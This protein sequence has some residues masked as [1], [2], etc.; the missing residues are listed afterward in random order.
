MM[1]MMMA[2]STG[3]LPL[4]RAAQ[5]VSFLLHLFYLINALRET[6]ALTLNKSNDDPPI[7]HIDV[8]EGETLSMNCS[9]SKAD[10]RDKVVWQR[11]G[12]SD[13]ILTKNKKVK[14]KDSRV[15]MEMYEDASNFTYRLTILNTSTLDDGKY[16]CVATWKNSTSV[17]FG[18]VTVSVKFFP[19]DNPV[20]SIEND[21]PTCDTAQGNPPVTMNWTTHGTG[22]VLEGSTPNHYVDG[23]GRGHLRSEICTQKVNL[24]NRVLVC[25]VSG[26][27]V[28]SG[29]RRICSIS[30]VNQSTA[31]EN[32]TAVVIPVILVSTFFVLAVVFLHRK[33]HRRGRTAVKRKSKTNSCAP[34]EHLQNA[35]VVVPYSVTHCQ[36]RVPVAAA[37]YSDFSEHEPVNVRSVQ[38]PRDTLE[39]HRYSTIGSASYDVLPVRRG[40]AKEHRQ[41]DVQYETVQPCSS[42]S[43][44]ES[45]T[46][47]HPFDNVDGAK[48]IIFVS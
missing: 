23:K 40:S 10:Q 37:R 45:E 42:D 41:S 43:K 3:S 5:W 36:L 4:L 2:V 11:L 9:V 30:V 28:F 8:I 13:I 22:R 32:L 35:A 27:G 31:P 24:R 25:T 29:V 34:V 16:V 21:Y 44:P 7:E 12:E 47:S 48:N 26:T 15:S 18:N 19:R 17:S 6:G 1:V 33:R 38:A 46:G 39:V 14:I 20:C